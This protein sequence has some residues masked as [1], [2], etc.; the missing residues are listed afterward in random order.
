M[1]AQTERDPYEGQTRKQYLTGLAAEMDLPVSLVFETAAVLGP[2]E[3]FDG[4]VTMLE[5]AQD[6]GEFDGEDSDE[7]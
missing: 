1:N 5:D 7:Y 4:L 2:N 3:D 6:S